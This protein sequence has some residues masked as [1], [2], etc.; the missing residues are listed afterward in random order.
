MKKALVLTSLLLAFLV[1]CTAMWFVRSS[2][3]HLPDRATLIQRQVQ[4][5]RLANDRELL[6]VQL[7]GSAEASIGLIAGY[8]RQLTQLA[9]TP[10][11]TQEHRDL[12]ERL[13]HG[14]EA[15]QAKL[16]N[17]QKRR[18]SELVPLEQ[19]LYALQQ[20][21]ADPVTHP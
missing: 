8:T 10:A 2:G 19:R 20:Q 3:P 16:N 21:I 7:D 18:R 1:G 14:I 4:L 9:L 12:V 17:I 6:R 11:N 5:G 13:S 15:E